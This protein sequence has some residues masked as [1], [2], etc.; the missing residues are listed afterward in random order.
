MS[1]I[2]PETARTRS[3]WKVTEM[4]RV[5][6]VMKMRPG[7]PLEPPR[8]TTFNVGNNKREMD[9]KSTGKRKK[10]VK[11]PP[12]RARRRAIDPT[13]WDSVHLKGIWLDA[14][15]AGVAETSAGLGRSGHGDRVDIAEDVGGRVIQRK[16][17]ARDTE[18]SDENSYDEHDAESAVSSE[19]ED[20]DRGRVSLSIPESVVPPLELTLSP[21]ARPPLVESAAE[22]IT[23]ISQENL[24]SLALLR[25]LFSD[26]DGDEAWGGQESLSDIED[27]RLENTGKSRQSVAQV[28]VDKDDAGGEIE[29]VPRVKFRDIEMGDTSDEV[30]SPPKSQPR[31]LPQPGQVTQDQTQVRLKDL[32]AP[33]EEEGINSTTFPFPPFHAGQT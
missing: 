4:G 33:R 32:F 28:V 29:E 9:G 15:I 22:E 21:T 11:Q 30:G 5:V 8:L 18:S 24:A 16:G 12:T 26:K 31:S 6:R 23:S 17:H 27:A 14:E 20:D 25:S 10:R 3:G 19:D 7:R 1:L 13:R 2:T